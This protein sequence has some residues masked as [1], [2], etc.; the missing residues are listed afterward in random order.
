M[1][2][3]FS[4]FITHRVSHNHEKNR[5]P[6]GRDGRHD[7]GQPPPPAPRAGADWAI[8]V[9]DRDNEHYYQPG[10]LFVPFGFYKRENIVKPRAKFLP[11]RVEFII[12]EIDR[13]DPA[14]K[15]EVRLPGRQRPSPT[16]I[17]IV[18]T[19]AT[20]SRPRRP[21]CSTA[22][23][24]RSSISTRPTAPRPWPRSSR[25]PGRA[26]RHPRQRDAHQ[27]PGRPARVRLLLRRLPAP[28]SPPRQDRARLR[29]AAPRR[30]HQA[31]GLE[32]LRRTMLD[33]KRIRWSP[34]STPSASTPPPA[35]SSGTTAARSPTTCSSPSRPTWAPR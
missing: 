28:P 12:A 27:V 33:E 31:R 25:L 22:G 29:H 23:A 4:Q 5:H 32:D 21:A 30:L 19:G 7:H 17:L 6:R 9:V 34:T 26:D 8:T 3:F 11:Q 13:I 10:F 24:T 2:V 1:L 15:S 18:A 35:R 14:A 16:T 20:S